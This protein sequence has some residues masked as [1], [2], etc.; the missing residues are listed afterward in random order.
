MYYK[1]DSVC[2]ISHHLGSN[3]RSNENQEHSWCWSLLIFVVDLCCQSCSQSLLSILKLALR[4]LSRA[5]WVSPL[6]SMYLRSQTLALG[7]W[8]DLIDLSVNWNKAI[9]EA[10]QR[11]D[12]WSLAKSRSM[13]IFLRSFR[14]PYRRW[15]FPGLIFQ[16]TEIIASE[17]LIQSLYRGK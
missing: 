10:M 9:S 4:G 5:H 6:T 15:Y 16:Q 11:L 17:T 3:G 7:P 8:T 2:A 1:K 13:A 14:W 12:E